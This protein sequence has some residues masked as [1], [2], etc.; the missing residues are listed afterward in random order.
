[1]HGSVRA[2][3]LG[4]FPK[5]RKCA[6]RSW[7]LAVGTDGSN[8]ARRREILYLIKLLRIEDS[9][10]VKYSITSEFGVMK[11]AWFMVAPVL[12]ILVIASSEIWPADIVAIDLTQWI[13]PDIGMVGDDRFGALV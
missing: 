2:G 13:L 8:G 7:H 3:S 10:C 4:R 11:Q 9:P 1:M 6:M 5:I 12:A